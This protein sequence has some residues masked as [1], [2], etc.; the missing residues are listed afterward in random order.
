MIKSLPREIWKP[1]L[2]ENQKQMKRQYVVSNMGRVISY[3]KSLQDDGKLLKGSLS[4]GYRTLNL[5]IKKGNST[6]Y[7]HREVAKAFGKKKTASHKYVIH[8]NH[9]KGDNHIKNLRWVTQEEMAAHQQ[10]S[11]K[12]IEIGRAHV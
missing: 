7:F 2:L 4:A 1:M 12:K 9:K 8:L 11:P 5:H 6:I 3:S 10:K